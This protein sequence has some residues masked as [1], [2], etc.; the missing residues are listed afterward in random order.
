MSERLK[1]CRIPVEY[2]NKNLGPQFRSMS[3]YL[4]ACITPKEHSATLFFA[5]ADMSYTSSV[6]CMVAALSEL[7][8]LFAKAQN[9]DQATIAEKKSGEGFR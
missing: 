8:L 1:N 9:S 4:Q 2:R 7:C 3:D 6:A 5:A